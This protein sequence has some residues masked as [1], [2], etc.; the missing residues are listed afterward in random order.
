MSEPISPTGIERPLPEGASLVV[1]MDTEGRINYVNSAL[2]ELSGYSEAELIG[3]TLPMRH[4]DVPPAVFDH[5]WRTLRRRRPWRGV[6]KYLCKNGDHF[7]A[8]AYLVPIW[9]KGKIIGYMSVRTQVS[10]EQIAIAEENYRYAAQHGKVREESGLQLLRLLSVKRGVLTGIAFVIAATC[11]STWIGVTGLARSSKLVN[12][13][14]QH[15]QLAALA[16]EASQ[17]AALINANVLLAFQHGPDGKSPER[18][19]KVAFADHLGTI[20][21]KTNQLR[22][23]AEA[24]AKLRSSLHYATDKP[25]YVQQMAADEEVINRH[26]SSTHALISQ[27]IEPITKMLAQERF[28]EARFAMFDTFGPLAIELKATSVQ[29]NDSLIQSD[30]ALRS[31]LDEVYDQTVDQLILW[32]L[33]TAAIVGVSGIFF[34]RGTMH[35]LNR[36]MRQMQK[37]AEG[38]LSE[39]PDVFGFGE[40][41]KVASTVATM[42][43]QLKVMIDEV[44]RSSN[45]VEQLVQTLNGEIISI[46]HNTEDQYAQAVQIHEALDRAGASTERLAEVSLSAFKILEG[47]GLPDETESGQDSGAL[48]PMAKEAASLANLNALAADEIKRLSEKIKALVADSRE[49]VNTSWLVGQQLGEISKRLNVMLEKFD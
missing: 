29:L 6:L 17:H 23:S 38:H 12:E 43:I 24:L 32:S 14:K 21:T 35:P 42:Q 7:W 41:G 22:A 1:K 5:L 46:L 47:L 10:P 40:T 3:Q 39:K 8:D 9:Q 49:K 27:G 34:F 31:R 19:D 16:N 25:D 48:L 4:P 20:H 30:A 11:V 13:L 2:T 37:I 28:E 15:Q 26:L 36:A 45:L 18:H 33:I 44:Q